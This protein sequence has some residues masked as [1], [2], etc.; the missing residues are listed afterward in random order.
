MRIAANDER[1][2]NE[3]FHIYNQQLWPFVIKL[4]GSETASEEIL[5]EV[6]LKIWMQ[7]ERLPQIENP[8]AWIVRLV[9]NQSLNYLRRLAVEGRFFQYL[10]NASASHA[11][12]PEELLAAKETA[13]FIQQVIDELP[14]QCRQVYLLSREQGLSIPEIADRLNI[15]PNTVKNQ[16]VKAL[17]RIRAAVQKIPML[18]VFWFLHKF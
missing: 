17:S 11:L 8:K 16:L 4:S 13:G 12:S 7:R 6:F 15:S 2:F 1:A 5:Q 9:S 10:K 14:P 3:L 18:W